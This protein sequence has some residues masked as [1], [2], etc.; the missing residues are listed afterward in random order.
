M[1]IEYSVIFHSNWHCGSGLAAGADV[2]ALVIKDKNAL[3][4]IPGK[5]IKGLIR[6][7]VEDYL[8][9]TGDDEET[10]N[11]FIG[12]FGIPVSDNCL[13]KTN[14]DAFFTNVEL[15]DSLRTNIIKAELQK[16]L[17]TNVASTA[18]DDDGIAKKNSLRRIEVTVPCELTGKIFN[19]NDKIFDIIIKSFGFIKHIG[20]NRNRG[21]GRCTVSLKGKEGKNDNSTI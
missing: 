7:A 21:L 19:V 1:I 8:Q 13:D 12:A 4:Y 18:I 20:V 5:T 3:P 16:Y 10:R 14:G 17:Y 11:A 2:D 6:E 15:E 9:F